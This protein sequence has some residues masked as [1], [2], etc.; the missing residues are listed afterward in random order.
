MNSTDLL[1]ILARLILFKDSSARKGGKFGFH[2]GTLLLRKHLEKAKLCFSNI[3]D[4][5]EIIG[6]S[7]EGAPERLTNVSVLKC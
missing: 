5:A 4:G 3:E 7:C 6:L 1:F 2:I